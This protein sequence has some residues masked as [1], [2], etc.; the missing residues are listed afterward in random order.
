MQVVS[1]VKRHY[2]SEEKNLGNFLTVKITV[3][4]LLS[5]LLNEISWAFNSPTVVKPLVCT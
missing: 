1:D 3:M 5:C 2:I 4:A